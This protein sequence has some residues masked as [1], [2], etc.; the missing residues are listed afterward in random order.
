MLIFQLTRFD[1]HCTGSNKTVIRL[2]QLILHH[3]THMLKLAQNNQIIYI[4][5]ILLATV[6]Y[7]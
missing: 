3:N 6:N 4:M 2:T 1:M 7:T 5:H